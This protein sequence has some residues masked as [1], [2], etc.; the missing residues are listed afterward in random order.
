MT[1]TQTGVRSRT[2]RILVA[3]EYS[4]TVRDAFAARG[5]DAWSCD[6]RPT[7]T[8]GQHHMGDVTPLLKEPW[9][10]VIAH[11]TC[12][13]LTNSGARW[14]YEKWSPAEREA[15]AKEGV[16]LEG[17]SRRRDEQRWAELDEAA[18]FFNLFKTANA[19]FIA[20]ENPVMH[21]HAVKLVGGKATQF[22]QPYQFGHLESKRTG[23][24]LYNLPP[25]TPTDD[26]ET[27]MRELPKKVWNK[28]HYMSPGP[29]REKERSRTAVG[30]AQAMAD[31]WGPVVEDHVANTEAKELAA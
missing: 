16:T 27:R 9:D 15:A 11:P 7:E 21:G 25:L 10:L 2:P 4:G 14:L 12:R 30:I 6:L 29:D 31:Q 13:I 24:R 20:I 3:C 28:C 5:W 22:V 17:H 18:A 1:N 8:P 26:V 23:L 19:P